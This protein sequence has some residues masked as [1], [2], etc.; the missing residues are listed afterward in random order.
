MI[1]RFAA[2][3]LWTPHGF[4]KN[5]VVTMDA[6]GTVTD[7]ARSANIDSLRD[8]EYYNGVLMPSMVN[9]HCHLELSYL[10]GVLEPGGGFV[11]FG[12]QI[13]AKRGGFDRKA[14]EAAAR[15]RDA[16]MWSE[17]IGAV[18]DICNDTVTLDIKKRSHI[19]YHSF[20]ELYGFS[21]GARP[22]AKRVAEGLGCDLTPHSTYSVGEDDFRYASRGELLSIHFMESAGERELFSRRGEFWEWYED[23]GYKPDFFGYASP[24]QRIIDNIPAH[25]RVML[26]HNTFVDKDELA[27]LAA[28]FGENLT[29]VLCPRS[30][31][32]ISGSLPP[33]EMLRESGIRLALGTDSMASNSSLS[34][35]EE[36]KALEGVPIGELIGWATLGGAEALGI[37]DHTGTLDVGKKCGLVL[38]EG[39][40][41]AT[42]R[43]HASTTTRRII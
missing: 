27:A 5:H 32:Y 25:R 7:I 42:H 23:K 41:P 26:I 17:G 43:L 6:S 13:G 31:L 16:R 39:L 37:A 40:D 20:A 18:A 9:A 28:H 4:E 10:G 34:L 21:A 8:V 14:V 2:Q 22:A 30:N 1:R 35:V 29:L 15:F 38:L 33:V 3:L 11:S 12:R 19:H 36:M 24:C